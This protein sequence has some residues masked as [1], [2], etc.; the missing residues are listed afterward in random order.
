MTKQRFALSFLLLAVS[1]YSF[2][3]PIHQRKDITMES[4]LSK[5]SPN[6]FRAMENNEK[7]LVI[8]KVRNVN[9]R[10]IHLEERIYFAR[11]DKVYFEGNLTRL[12]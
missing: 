8:E 12:T 7:Y 1:F 2:S 3:Q 5:N 4:I 10:K 11:L 9:R 6:Q